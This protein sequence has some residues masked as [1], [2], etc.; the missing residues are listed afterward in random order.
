M[1]VYSERVNS[2][3]NTSE[4]RDS[5]ESILVGLEKNEQEMVEL[6]RDYSSFD[7][8]ENRFSCH[9]AN[10]LNEELKN[11]HYTPSNLY[12]ENFFQKDFNYYARICCNC[13][14]DSVVNKFLTMIGHDRQFPD[15]II[16]G[17]N[18]MNHQN[19]FIEVKFENN[20]EVWADFTKL[21]N[22]RNACEYLKENV[23]DDINPV[24]FMHIMLFLGRDLKDKII[25]AQ[26]ETKELLRKSNPD[27]IC[28]YKEENG[29]RCLTLGE[30][31]NEIAQEKE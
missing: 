3:A 26:N 28:I 18:N 11:R 29:F 20:P 23:G 14:N 24:F 13:N 19:C 25:R 30:L 9:L 27:I 2:I 22:F 6:Q 8:N 15:I 17:P 10:F 5:L 21:T 16:H 1:V 12:A 7:G 31:L 4:L